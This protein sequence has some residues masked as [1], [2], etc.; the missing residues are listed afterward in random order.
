MGYLDDLFL[1]TDTYDYCQ[2]SVTD[3]VNIA[4]KVKFSATDFFSKCD[5]ICRELWIWSHLLSSFFAQCNLF[6]ELDFKKQQENV[7]FVPIK[8]N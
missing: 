3:T 4:Q 2:H 1:C 7:T 6:T 5:Q 8:R